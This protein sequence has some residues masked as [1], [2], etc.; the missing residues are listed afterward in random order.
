MLKR[1][2]VQR[3]ARQRKVGVGPQPRDDCEVVSHLWQ[4]PVATHQPWLRREL[5]VGV[6]QPTSFQFT[7]AADPPKFARGMQLPVKVSLQR[8]ADVTG[9]IRFR[10]LTTQVMPKKK[11][12]R[13]KKDVL[14]DDLDRAI[15]LAS[16]P[17]ISRATSETNLNV[18]VP[19]GLPGRAWGLVL[20]AELLSADKK[21][22]V[23]RVVSPARQFA[24]TTPLTVALTGQAHV[25]AKAGLGQTGQLTG[26]VQRAAGFTHPVTITLA[27]L[28]KGYAPPKIIVPADQ[29]EFSF[30][31]RFAYGAKPGELKNLQLLALV[32]PDPKKANLVVR[33]DPIKIEVKVVPGAKPPVAEPF[34]LFEDDKKM[35]GYLTKGGGKASLE[36]TDKHSG[37]V[38][39][40]VTPDQRFNELIPGLGLKIREKPGPGEFRYLRFAWKKK[41]GKSICLQL[42]HDGKWGP[43]AG[44]KPG[45]KFRYHAGPGGECFGAS[46]KVGDQ[47][48][49]DF[50][51]MTRG[52]G[53]AWQISGID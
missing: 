39:L 53:V 14:V 51:L 49:G 1:R 11:V 9:D 25:E 22:V 18:A 44:T 30:P 8:N 27:S 15:R 43:T 19:T 50:V 20:V 3:R 33:S 16:S 46:L 26:K 13:N 29:S 21:S 52:A 2:A 6:G 5:A 34:V 17:L 36:T 42:N 28:P 4:N 7:W 32:T 31:I 37:T 48:P 45:A 23:T 47:L 12:K 24:P 35:L 40:K 38:S 10:L 41:G